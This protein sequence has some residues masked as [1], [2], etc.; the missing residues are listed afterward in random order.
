MRL[1]AHLHDMDPRYMNSVDRAIQLSLEVHET[2]EMA[3]ET[4]DP[5]YIAKAEDELHEMIMVIKKV[6]ETVEDQ[7]KREA[8]MEMLVLLEEDYRSFE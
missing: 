7:K 1:P 3:I 2:F 8:L 4:L 5:A 6:L